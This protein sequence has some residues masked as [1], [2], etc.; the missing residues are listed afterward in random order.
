VAETATAVGRAE[1][2]R[3]EV[4][5]PP[6]VPERP[7]YR[8]AVAAAACAWALYALTLAPATAFWDT[9]EY[10]ATAHILGIPHPPGNPLF[11][12]LA[13][14]WTL[15][16]APLSLSI[17]VRVNLLAATTSA[18]ATGLFYL[19][20]HRVLMGIFTEARFARLGAAASAALGATA[21]TVWNQSNVNEKVYTLSVLVIA[22]V[23]WLAVRWRDRRAEP[24]SAR[25][26]LWA[27]FVL[28]LGFTNHPMSVLP[29]PALAVFVLMSGPH[30]LLSGAFLGRAAVLVVLGL[31]FNFVLPVRASLDPVINEGDPTCETITG[32]AVAVYTN[33]RAGCPMLADNLTRRQYQTPPVTERKAPFA[34]QMLM[35]WQYFE[36]QWSRGFEASELPG[37]TRLPFALLFLGLG[38]AGL[39]VTW[40]SDRT[41]FAYVAV[42]AATL[43]VGL[44][45]YLNF[46]YGYSLAP[47]ITDPLQ[48]EVRERDYFFVA[49]FLLWGVLAGLG[50]AW[51]WHT[52]AGS[53][54]GARRYGAASPVLLIALIPLAL[55]WSWASRSGDYAARDWAYDLLVSVEPYGV[56]FTNGDNDTFPL[57]YLQEV[58][59]I[60][61][62]VTVV[63]GQYL[64][65]TWYPR[66]LQRL[67]EPDRQRPYVP[68]VAPAFH[69]VREPP[70]ESILALTPEQMDRVASAR[71]AEDVTI[72]F[73]GIAVRYPAGMVLGR[74]HQLAL[75]IIRDSIGDRPI[76]FSA[77]G[78]MLSEL[79]LDPWG[80]R[81]GLTT[82][83]EMRSL[84]QPPPEG[85][86]QGSEPY[87]SGWFELDRSLGLYRD[88]YLFRGLRDR[89]VWADRS[90]LNIPLQYY[91]L[92]LQLADAAEV[93][94]R[95]PE[96]VAALREDA[97]AFQIV[98]QGGTGGTPGLP[99]GG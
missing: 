55:N 67:T 85:L 88:V 51:A 33:G 22:A 99:G 98:G 77:R 69:E 8:E 75:A 39:W 71:L 53:T 6:A 7:P 41:I 58:E 3:G 13:K 64:L 68:A 27:V 12:V 42:L 38:G 65:T 9:S 32:A 19:V 15:L 63:V 14:V 49:G 86:V 82:K 92:A 47:E 87:G 44:V 90:T 93:G 34:A 4:T 31:S 59:G 37:G 79:G 17:A 1:H 5:P 62:D 89:A 10:I 23:S 20:A 50:L 95:S 72:G 74:D 97:M 28:A 78:G 45:V 25:Y 56:L 84:E 94:G 30:R 26:L 61:R 46:W 29:A 43:T 11:V 76:F 2:A 24:G 80:V 16:L 96:L 48:H 18:A 70:A 73:P 36:W 52:V 40:R 21:F 57:W 54:P 35:Y 81:H 83:L 66:Q 60:R 91:V